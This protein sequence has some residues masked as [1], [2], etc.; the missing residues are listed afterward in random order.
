MNFENEIQ[1]SVNYLNSDA[2]RETVEANEQTNS[3]LYSASLLQTLEAHDN[4]LHRQPSV[5]PADIIH[6]LRGPW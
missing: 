3:Y 1:S 5:K 2:A 6:D 4:H